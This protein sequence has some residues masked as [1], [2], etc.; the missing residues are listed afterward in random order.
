MNAGPTDSL[1]EQVA[2]L[3]GVH[4]ELLDISMDFIDLAARFASLPGT[5]ILLS[6]GTMDCARYHLLGAHPWLT[7]SGRRGKTCLQTGSHRID[8]NSAPLDVLDQVLARLDLPEDVR[9][10]PMAAGLMG[11]LAYDL[12]DDLEHLPRTS[13]DDGLLPSLLLYAPSI[14]VVHDRETGSTRLMIPRHRKLPDAVEDRRRLF[15]QTL[16]DPVDRSKTFRTA[17]DG[18][19]SNFTRPAYEAAVQR[20]ID[21]IAAGDVYQ[22]NLSQRFQTTFEGDG[23][24]LFRRLFEANPAPFFAYVHAGD[25][26]IVSTSP[27]RFLLRDADRVEARPIKGTRPRGSTPAEDARLRDELAAS[28]KDDAELSMIVDLLRNDIGRVCAPGSVRVTRHKRLEAYENVYHLVSIVEGRLDRGQTSVDLLQATFPG[29]SVT[30]CPK[31]RA[32]QIID[33]LE[34][35][36]RHVYCGSIG[37]VSFHDTMDLS[38]AIRTATIVNDTLRYSVGGGIVFDSDPREEFEETLHKGRTLAAACGGDAIIRPAHRPTAW[39]NGRLVPAAEAHVPA[40]DLGLHYGYGFFETLRADN[41]TVPLLSD[42]LA[43]LEATWNALMPADPPDVTWPDVI[44]RV[45]CAN[46]LEDSTAA[47]KILVTRGTRQ[48]PPWDF[49]LLVTARPYRHRLSGRSQ[50]GLRLGSYPYPR[51]SPLAAHKTLNYLYYLQAGFWAA[52]HGHDEALVY[53]PDNSISETNTANLLLISGREVIR[54]AS[55]AVLPGVMA[56]AACRQLSAWGYR[57]AQRPVAA[58]Q[59]FSAEQVLAANALMGVVPVI[60]IDGRGRRPGNDLWQRLNAA[61]LPGMQGDWQR[62]HDSAGISADNPPDR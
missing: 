21:Y 33:E 48:A 52:R 18:P 49:T 46:Q 16:A 27:E 4:V 3:S 41:G 44:A 28:P 55:P 42:H 19:A 51:Q 57:V 31:V 34:T 22:V 5:V 43:R 47:V 20:V 56:T 45:L 58:G 38:I 59:L 2:P 54:P 1:L 24:A 12:K 29:G 50:P 36:R 53:N 30:G 17:A 25:H 14:L 10:A 61:V 40:T 62:P 23:F 13:V 8:L 11:Y 9:P 60:A 26:Q 35:C 7:L 37:Y 32:M 15:F 39:L 6:G